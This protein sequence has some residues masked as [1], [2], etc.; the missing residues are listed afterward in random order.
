MGKRA[1]SGF[2]SEAWTAVARAVNRVLRQGG[3]PLSVVL[4]KITTECL[5]NIPTRID[6][7]V[8]EI[9][10]QQPEHSDSSLQAYP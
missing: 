6:I 7:C 9:K 8:V 10:S 3:K 4:E 2:I 1:Q 5:T